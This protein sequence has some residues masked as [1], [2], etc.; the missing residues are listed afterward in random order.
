MAS[1]KSFLSASALAAGAFLAP[2][3]VA[4]SG[5]DANAASPGPGRRRRALAIRVDAARAQFSAG[6]AAS[7]SNGDERRYADNRAS[8]AKTLPHNDLGEVQTSD[9]ARLVAIVERED[10]A[11]FENI[12]RDPLAVERINNPQA[13]YASDLVAADSEVPKIE[14][15][16]QFASARMAVEI[17]RTAWRAC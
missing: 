14:P 5:A 7:N 17:G 1:R 3:D 2:G 6:V 9:F 11:G 12:P 8:F 13:M 15:P 4:A 10:P 16:P